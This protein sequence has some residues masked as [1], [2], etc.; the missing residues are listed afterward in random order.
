MAPLI[1]GEAQALDSR[2][3]I[4]QIKTLSEQVD[5]SLRRER[6]LAVLSGFFGLLALLLAA[7]GLYAT[8][9]YSVTRRTHEIGI[10]I[11]LGA[12][13][14]D[15]LKLVLLQA[16]RLVL[17]GMGMGLIATVALTRVIS[18]FLFGVTATDPATLIG[19]SLL[20]TGV[21]LLATYIPAHR[22]MKVDPMVALREE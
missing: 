3:P 4:L 2:V 17:I 7:V 13:R 9:S 14:R 16:S 8:I 12:E 6:L 20:L 22:A 21:A 5:E 1:R 10:R 15:I 18:S 11:A 19:I